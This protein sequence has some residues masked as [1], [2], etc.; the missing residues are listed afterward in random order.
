MKSPDPRRFVALNRLPFTNFLGK[1]HPLTRVAPVGLGNDPAVSSPHPLLG[2]N[3]MNLKMLAA[4][5]VLA[6]ALTVTAPVEAGHGCCPPPPVK[7]SLCVVD[8]CTGCSTSVCVCL[9][10]CCAG[11]EACLAGCRKA[12]LGRKVLTYKYPCGHC[13]EVVVKRN[14]AVK[15]R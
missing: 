12:C 11:Q 1:T 13:V 10:A 14:G 2:D 5:A 15:V 7:A 9:P 3:P 4:L 6:G 8:P